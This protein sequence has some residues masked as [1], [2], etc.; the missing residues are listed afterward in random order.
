M[1]YISMIYGLIFFAMS[2]IF[3]WKTRKAIA[4]PFRNIFWAFTAFS[5]MKAISILSGLSLELFSSDDMLLVNNMSPA[6]IINTFSL[7]SSGISNVVLYHFGISMLTHR[8]SI[9]LDYKIF[10]VIL[11]LL[12][13]SLYFLGIVP[14]H[15]LEKISRHSFGLNGAFLGSIGCFNLFKIKR[16]SGEKKLLSGLIACGIGL[17]L[18]SFTEGFISNPV[19]GIQ[20]ELLRIF[21]AIVLFISSFFVVDLLKSEKKDRVGFI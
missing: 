15:E 1:T 21:S 12:Y 3:V 8:G 5:I 6:V 2:L 18:Y 4:S 11:F 13:M 9:R 20:V 7:I 14:P 19:F 10:P 16:A 17:I